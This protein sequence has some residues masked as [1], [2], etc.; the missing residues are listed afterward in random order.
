MAFC[1]QIEVW[2]SGACEIVARTHS[3]SPS[4]YSTADVYSSLSRQS[5]GGRGNG[6]SVEAGDDA[7]YLQVFEGLLRHQV[8]TPKTVEAALVEVFAVI[9]PVRRRLLSLMLLLTSEASMVCV[10]DL[11]FKEKSER[12]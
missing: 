2:V 5:R 10:T 11:L 4:L 7:V 8:L 6:G 3:L 12:T 1:Y 9:L